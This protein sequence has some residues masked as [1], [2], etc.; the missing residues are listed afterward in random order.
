MNAHP[1]CHLATL[2]GDQPR[3]RGMMM[4]RADSTGILFHVGAHKSLRCQIVQNPRVEVCFN[5][6]SMQVRIA[7]T[8]EI[9]DDLDLKKEIVEARPFMQSFVAEQ[10][11]DVFIV[12]RVTGC[13]YTVWTMDTNFQPTEYTPL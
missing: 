1:I 11:Y 7:G 13:R 4:Y 12:F 5:S 10:G 6:E 9:L 3:V 2:E 8:V